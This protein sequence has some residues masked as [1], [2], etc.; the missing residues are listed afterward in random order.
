M[1]GTELPAAAPGPPSRSAEALS[2]AD[3]AGAILP[4][5]SSLQMQRR[6]V[7]PKVSSPCRNGTSL[8]RSNPVHL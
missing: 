5:Q 8:A 2:R 6:T 7:K 4:S 1:K 3:G